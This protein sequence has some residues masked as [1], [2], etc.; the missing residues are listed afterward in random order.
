[1]ST[2]FVIVISSHN[3]N[4]KIL[5]IKWKIFFSMSGVGCAHLNPAV[6]ILKLKPN[7]RTHFTSWA[8]VI[9]VCRKRMK[10]LKDS[11]K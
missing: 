4:R 7:D 6:K 8:L 10:Y 3:M 1:M 2:C 9:L 11:K 5:I